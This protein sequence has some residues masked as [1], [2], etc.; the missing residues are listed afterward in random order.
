MKAFSMILIAVVIFGF[1]ASAV[2]LTEHQSPVRDRF[3][4]ET[5]NQNQAVR[6]NLVHNLNIGSTARLRSKNKRHG[7]V[8]QKSHGS[9]SRRLN[10]IEKPKE[11]ETKIRRPRLTFV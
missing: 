6:G 4:V 1:G 9:L 7:N 2:L 5:Q 10:Q 8:R 11:K 3:L